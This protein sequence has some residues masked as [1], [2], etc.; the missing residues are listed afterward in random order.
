MEK[1]ALAAHPLHELIAGRWSPYG[2]A[3]RELDAESLGSLLEAARW[4]PSSFNEQPWRFLVARRG[5]SEAFARLADCL[6]SG[7][8]WAREAAV[9]MLSVASTSFARNGKPNRHA[10]HDVGL[11]TQNLVL[12]AHALGL[13][14]HQMAGFDVERARTTLG[15]PEGHEPVTMIAVGHPAR[16]DDA[17]L[18]QREE[19]PRQRRDLAEIVFGAGWDEPLG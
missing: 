18:R 1:R 7:N 12:Q 6:V 11:A 2:F 4:A 5:D 15:I 17:G 13:S 19:A 3:R 10:L 9:L 8:A 16:P 14:T